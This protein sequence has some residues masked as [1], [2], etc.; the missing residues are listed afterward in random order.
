MIIRVA[1]ASRAHRKNDR[2]QIINL[3]QPSEWGGYLAHNNRGGVVKERLRTAAIYFT[4]I[5]RIGLSQA[6]SAFRRFWRI[7]IIAIFVAIVNKAKFSRAQNP[8]SAGLSAPAVFTNWQMK[9][10]WYPLPKVWRFAYFPHCEP[11]LGHL[12]CRILKTLWI[13]IHCYALKFSI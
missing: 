8:H 4:W 12:R 1:N 11:D 13:P 9:N 10:Y 7:R 5:F 6:G 2:I 3:L